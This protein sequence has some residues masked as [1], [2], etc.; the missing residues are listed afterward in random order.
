MAGLEKLQARL[1]EITMRDGTKKDI[2]DRDKRRSSLESRR[3]QQGSPESM[4]LR[5]VQSRHRGA[6]I[7]RQDDVLR[8][9]TLYTR[10]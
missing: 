8:V 5:E 2:S 6:T 7:S 1:D 3:R 4:V 9:E 10:S